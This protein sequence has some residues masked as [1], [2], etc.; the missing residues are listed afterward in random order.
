MRV[1]VVVP[2]YNEENTVAKIL[3]MLS[4]VAL[5]LEVIVVD[6]ASTDR[7]WE[8]L[9]Q[10]RQNAPFDSYQYVRHEQNQGKGAGLRTGFR[11]ATGDLVTVQDADMEYDPQDIPGLVRK[12]E[13]VT[14]AGHKRVAIYGYRDLAGQ[15]FTTRWGNRFLTTMTNVLFGSRIHDMETCYKLMPGVVA[16]ALPMTGRRFEIE[17][18]ITTCI[19]KAGY[20]IFEVPISYYPREEKKL[21][22]W[23]DGWPALAMLLQQRFGKP[24]RVNEATPVSTI[25]P[26]H[27]HS[28]K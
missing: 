28:N 27:A 9:Q 16:H 14:A 24:F 5:D 19:L 23:K 6:D 10:I 26:E 13:E 8:I 3:E 15:K 2:V 25:E 21:S 4:N 12:W 22:P 1:S 7:T 11:L 18:E 17:P 20:S